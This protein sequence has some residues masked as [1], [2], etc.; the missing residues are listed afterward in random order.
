MVQST[1]PILIGLITLQNGHLYIGVMRLLD[2]TLMN[3]VMA[4][5]YLAAFEYHFFFV[6][7]FLFWR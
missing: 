3:G 1:R 7:K 5:I 6:I 2:I 4:L